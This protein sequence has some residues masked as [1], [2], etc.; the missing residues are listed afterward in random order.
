MRKLAF[1]VSVLVLGCGGSHAKTPDSGSGSGTDAPS[2]SG[3]TVT[4]TFSA[5]PTDPSTFSFLVASQD[6]SGAWTLAAAPSGDV[7]SFDIKSSSYG[8]AWTCVGEGLVNRD[9]HL[10]YYTVAETKAVSVTVPDRCLSST[11]PT[12]FNL[13]GDIGSATANTKINLAFGVATDEVAATVGANGTAYTIA[14]LPG[15]HDLVLGND[16]ATTGPQAATDHQVA[17]TV[18]VD[19]VAV[20]ADTTQAINDSAGSATAT[21]SAAVTLTPT[22]GTTTVV[23]TDLYTG[24]GTVFNLVRQT[25][26]T[27]AA[28]TF[29]T[30]GL[31]SSEADDIYN[32]QIAVT[33]ATSGSIL[34]VQSWAKTVAAQTYTAP[35]AFA[36]TGST[37][38]TSTPYPMIKTTWNTYTDAVG[39]GW[40]AEQSQPAASCGSGF[41]GA[42]TCLVD[43][44]MAVSVGAAGT[45]PSVEM[46]DLSTLA[47]WDARFQFQTGTVVNGTIGT[48]TSSFG[49]GDFPSFNT[50]TTAGT[51]SL[52]E[53]GW[54]VTP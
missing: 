18:R 2:G 35:A 28:P 47:G 42:T 17:S 6:G 32:Q 30:R 4:L 11:A 48:A 14:T 44:S 33:D 15:T 46:P 53:G 3:T 29:V 25:Y 26:T 39:Y 21:G 5:L 31:G 9:V 51:R 16:A 40:D 10:Y 43:W 8:L 13:S 34:E 54:A 36:D 41:T 12:T 37:V 1:L 52:A 24:N 19:A 45:A 7:Y 38:A 22:T 20:T 49:S 50:P 27:G 23:T